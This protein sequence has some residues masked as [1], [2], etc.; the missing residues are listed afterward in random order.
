MPTTIKQSVTLPASAKRLYAMYVSASGHAQITG[1]P[2][3]IGAK[4]GTTFSAFGGELSGTMLATVPGRLVV[5]SW[6]SSNFAPNDPDSILVL[7][8]THI[9]AKSARVDLVHVNVSAVDYQGVKKGWPL[10]YWKPWRKALT[11]SR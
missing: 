9:N 1:A 3:K 10:Y 11:N 4:P 2:A 6:R 7:S 5:Q 8:F